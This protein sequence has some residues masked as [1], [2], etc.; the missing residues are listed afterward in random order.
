MSRESSSPS[1][2]SPSWTPPLSLRLPPSVMA[3]HAL[4]IPA[5]LSPRSLWSKAKHPTPP[6][7]SLRHPRSLRNVMQRRSQSRILKVP[8]LVTLAQIRQ[9]PTKPKRLAP[10][11]WTRVIRA[12]FALSARL[13]KT[14]S[15]KTLISTRAVTTGMKTSGSS[16]L[17]FSSPTA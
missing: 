15:R 12:C 13:F 6:L 4:P 2:M 16:E 9:S 10:S 14:Y 3:R 11:S 1:T 5:P 7:A 17:R 8:H